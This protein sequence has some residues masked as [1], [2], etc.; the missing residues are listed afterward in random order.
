MR[1]S[2]FKNFSFNNESLKNNGC[3]MGVFRGCQV[4]GTLALFILEARGKGFPFP[5]PPTLSPKKE[6]LIAGYFIFLY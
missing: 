3:I 1:S 4:S 6:R 5:C 2:S